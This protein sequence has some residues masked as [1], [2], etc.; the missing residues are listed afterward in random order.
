MRGRSRRVDAR[1]RSRQDLIDELPLGAGVAID[2]VTE[3]AREL[4]LQLQVSSAEIWS[5]A[6]G[7]AEADPPGPQRRRQLGQ[8]Q[9]VGAFP[10]S[11]DGRLVEVVSLG[12]PMYAL[13]IAERH[14]QLRS[15]DRVGKTSDR[16][17]H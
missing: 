4:S 2:V 7:V 15:G 12:R 13:G 16:R 9:L 3:G 1:L 11:V 10:P 6:Q 14:E 17:D 5:R 8:V